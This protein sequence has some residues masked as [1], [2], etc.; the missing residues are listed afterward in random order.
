MMLIFPLSDTYTGGI[1]RWD[2]LINQKYKKTK[3]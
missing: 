2:Y 3:F 1:D